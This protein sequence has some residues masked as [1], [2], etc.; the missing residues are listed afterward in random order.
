MSDMASNRL[1]TWLFFVLVFILSWG[2][3]TLAALSAT[4]GA[5]LPARLLHYAGGLM[6]IAVTIALIYL[7]HTLFVII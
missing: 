3:W 2:F 6:P 7:R 5:A 1:H 4:K